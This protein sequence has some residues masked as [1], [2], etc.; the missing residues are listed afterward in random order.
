MQTMMIREAVLKDAA[1]IA[2]VH[3]ESWKT[4]YRGIISDQ[5]LDSL[6]YTEREKRW[7]ATLSQPDR[8]EVIYVAED[9]N[10]KIVGFISGGPNRSDDRNYQGE[11]YAIYLLQEAQGKGVGLKLVQALVKKLLQ[12]KMESM[13]VWVLAGN[14]SRRFYEAL[15]GTPVRTAKISIG[16]ENYEEIA[17]GWEN[18]QSILDRENRGSRR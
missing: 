1:G 5:F 17:Y 4:T 11:L 8:R 2:N 15:G 7:Q 9:N 13:M 16:G 12:N 10:R 6:S 3:V 18:I 14:P